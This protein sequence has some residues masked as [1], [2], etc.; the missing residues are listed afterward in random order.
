MKKY[1]VDDKKYWNK[2]Y[3]KNHEE[4]FYNTLFAEYVYENWIQN[5][6]SLL[7]Y[8]CGNG[9][10]SLYFGLKGMDVSG[11][12][13][14]ETAIKNLKALKSQC[15]FICDD[16]INS[17]V[18]FKKQYDVC[19][20]RFTIHAINLCDE[21]KLIRNSYNVLKNNGL[22]CIEVR[23]V[24]DSLYGKGMPLGKDEYIFNSHYRRF[25]RINELLER[26][27][28]EGFLIKYAEENTGFA[29]LN[30][31]DPQIIRVIAAKES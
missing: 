4:I 2:F 8:G 3:E 18:I 27:I 26:L 6:K 17:E 25:I 28:N 16:F 22:F 13:A 21:V 7:E 31:S 24:F 29:P 30:N 11:V 15:H 19:Y 9:R 10:D 20:S 12:D 5:R 1:K 23:S 14:S